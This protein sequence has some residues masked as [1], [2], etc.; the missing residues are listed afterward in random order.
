MWRFTLV[1]ST[2]AFLVGCE[3]FKPHPP[4]SPPQDKVD[5]PDGQALPVA[6]MPRL[7]NRFPEPSKLAQGHVISPLAATLTVRGNDGKTWEFEVGPW[8]GSKSTKIGGRYRFGDVHIGDKVI[9]G[10]DTIEGVNFAQSLCIVRRPGGKIPV[11][12]WTEPRDPWPWHVAMQSR[13][14]FEEKG[15][16]MPPHLN[17]KNKPGFLNGVLIPKEL[18]TPPG[19][20]GKQPPV[21]PPPKLID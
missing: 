9:V 8:L 3:P 2:A 17:L 4:G 16:P 15:T 21:A 12:P 10:Y 5:V 1:L 14:D 11:E 7:A 20:A 13:Q 6:P 18:L 19:V